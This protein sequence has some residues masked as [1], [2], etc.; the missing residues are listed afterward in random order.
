MARI[1]ALALLLALAAG[2]GGGGERRDPESVVRA[3]S[4]AINRADDD[5]AAD[6]FAPDA[7]I[8][9]GG[10]EATLPDHA[11]ARRWNSGLPCSGTIVDLSVDG[12]AVTATFVLGERPGHAC[13]GDGA[14]ASVLIRVESGRIVLWHQ[15]PTTPSASGPGP[16]I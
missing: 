11:A 13:D 5:A 8:I 15:T 2:C 7:R 16:V 14:E 9:Q 6:L 12:D 4:D 1:A 3:W 10:V